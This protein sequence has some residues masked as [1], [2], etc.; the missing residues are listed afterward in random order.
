[1]KN[2][3]HIE[4]LKEFYREHSYTYHLDPT[5]NILLALYDFFVLTL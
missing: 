3:K 1:M 2:F 5:M 4:K